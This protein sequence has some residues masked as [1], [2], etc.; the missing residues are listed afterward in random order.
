MTH[1][2]ETG[3]KNRYQKT[4]TGFLQVHVSCNSIP[5]FSGTEI[6]ELEHCSI[7]REGN[8]YGFSDTGFRYRFLDSVSWALRIITDDIDIL[9]CFVSL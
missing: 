8:R 4:R 7:L 5:I 6:Y 1:Y 9:L 2:P 3:T